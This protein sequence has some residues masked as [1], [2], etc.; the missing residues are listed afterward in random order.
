MRHTSQGAPAAPSSASALITQLTRARLVHADRDSQP[1]RGAAA[2]HRFDRGID[3]DVPQ[4]VCRVRDA[5]SST[6]NT[7]Q[8]LSCSRRIT[9]SRGY[10]EVQIPG[11]ALKSGKTRSTQCFWVFL[12]I[13]IL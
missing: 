9:G 1:P 12:R 6:T 4:L 3:G 5:Y 13:T 8:R 10:S 11:R 2:T 7:I